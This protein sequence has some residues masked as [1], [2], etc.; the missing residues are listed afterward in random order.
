VAERL[1]RYYRVAL[2]IIAVLSLGGL[3]LINN[4]IRYHESDSR[5]LN[6]AGRQRMLS[7]QLVKLAIA[8]YGRH[9]G[10]D[11]LAYHRLLYTW[12]SNHRQLGEG[13]LEMNETYL[14]K[15][16]KVLSGKFGE[17]EPVYKALSDDFEAFDHPGLAEA[18]RKIILDRILRNDPVFLNRMDEIVFQFDAESRKR[19]EDLRIIEYM[20]AAISLLT[21]LMEV[22]LVFRPIVSYTRDIIRELSESREALRQSNEKILRL[23]EERH[24]QLRMEDQIRSASLMEGQEE[25][26]RRLAR[27]LHDGVGQMLTGLNLLV[28]RLRKTPPGDENFRSRLEE[29]GD[30]IQEIIRAARQVSHNVMPDLLVDYGLGPALQALTDQLGLTAESEIILQRT[31]TERRLP[32]AQETGLYRIAQE[33]LTNALKHAKA[34]KIRIRLNFEPHCLVLN[35]RDNGQGFDTEKAS[36]W[37]NAGLE[38]MQ[39]RAKLLKA[40]FSLSSTP[41]KGTEI[42]VSVASG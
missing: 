33:A 20:M 36:G 24:V 28:A 26:R 37:Q 10:T 6:I 13:L 1:T 8:R 23:Q 7:Q 2:S 3:W 21:L 29:I 38:N 5:V 11:T 32:P 39:T 12:R 40:E 42:E 25:E 14:V 27:E 19:V 15:K 18:D 16:S 30:Y 41:G 22:L 31:G 34:S 9:T 4:A 35:I 17:I